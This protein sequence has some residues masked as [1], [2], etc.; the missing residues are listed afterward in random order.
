MRGQ[1]ERILI[2]IASPILGGAERQTLQVTRG[3]MALGAEVGVVAEPDVLRAAGRELGKA[4]PLPAPLRPPEG[5]S[6]KAGQRWQ[7]RAV[8][9]ILGRFDADAALV[10]CP[11]PTEGFGA[12]E[13]LGLA[14]IPA[15]AVVHLV[16]QV[17]EVAASERF[18]LAGIRAD[19]AA[20]SE[21][22]ARRLEALFGLPPNRVA[23]IPN[24]LPPCP[25]AFPAWRGIPPGPLL[26]QVGRL[27]IRKGAQFAPAIAERIAPARLLLAG[28]GP[29]AGSLKGHKGVHLMGQTDEVPALL[30]A[31]DAFLLP[32]EHEGCPLSVLEAARA[33][34]PILATRQALEAWPEAVE[35]ARFVLRDPAHIAETFHQAQGDAAGTAARI[36]R[37]AEIAAAWDE[38]AMIRRTSFLLAA[39]CR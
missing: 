2:I 10:C 17:W 39:A 35:M 36:A 15:L 8:S 33:G 20:V 22:S 25:P 9:G 6:P 29:L 31:S 11:L 5:L 38:A 19:W 18:A 30:A 32:S 23:A 21:P 1:P 12:L 3:F 26:L 37:A 14:G 34:C 24:G 4:L 13:A 28:E 7:R 27:D 16:P